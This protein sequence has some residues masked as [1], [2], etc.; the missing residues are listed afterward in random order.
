MKNPNSKKNLIFLTLFF[1]TFFLY[2]HTY[3]QKDKNSTKNTLISEEQVKEKQKEI[4]ENNPEYQKTMH[5]ENAS[6]KKYTALQ[7]NQKNPQNIQDF[8]TSEGFFLMTTGGT[9]SQS[10][11]SYKGF[12]SFCIK[13]YID[14]ILCNNSSTGEFDWN[15]LDIHSIEAIEIEDIPSVSET[16]FAGC[17][18][19]ITTKNGGNSL[20]STFTVSGYQ[21]NPFDTWNST[22]NYN[23]QFNK[24]NYNLG[25]N[26]LSA[27]NE[28]EKEASKGTNKYNYSRQGN[29][30]FGWNY[31]LNDYAKIYG[32]NMFF[33]NNLKADFSPNLNNGI[34]EDTYTRNSL[35]YAYK[36][37]NFKSDTSLFYN[38]SN[39]KYVN[40]YQTNN[41]DNT[42]CHKISLTENAS[43]L[44][45]LSAGF[46]AEFQLNK[47][48]GYRFSERFGF[49]KKF[50]VKSFSFEPQLIAF[51]WQSQ[52]SNF[53]ILPRISASYKG[54]TAGAFREFI[55]PTFNQLF[56]PDTTYAS[57]NPDLQPEQG[58]SAFAG[59][60]NDFFP[61]WIQYKFSYYENKIR[62]GNT[63][64]KLYPVNNGK[65]I[66]NVITIGFAKS[67]F[68]GILSVNFDGTYNGAKLLNTHKQIMWVPEW[69][70]HAGICVKLGIFMFDA[71]YSF[72]GKRF[73]SNENIDFYPAIHLVDVGATVNCSQEIQAFCK[74]NNLLDQR[75][76]YHDFYYIPS[77]KISIGVKIQK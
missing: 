43:W 6:V 71:D 70:S 32:S 13:V 58:W 44:F 31:I 55:L 22:L 61:L 35:N 51:M 59:Y 8:L 75:V 39:V 66:Y 1:T 45:D 27:Q 7:I 64:G 21:K 72:I 11:L 73:T 23:Q 19:K 77:R 63:N 37:N 14:G 30:S 18:I 20:H 26:I 56:W 3:I 65:G 49:S 57:G 50:D 54:F 74:V 5:Y 53:A 46:D 62:W 34:E 47:N 4:E 17:I 38:F 25:L 12:T 29:I 48:E 16:E 33:Y 68:D 28:F 9:G 40:N 67:F 24:F 15:S 76:V 69:Q 41:I 60:K 42:N 52:T 2:S 10:T 36:N